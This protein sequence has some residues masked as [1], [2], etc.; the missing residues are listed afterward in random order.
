MRVRESAGSSLSPPPAIP[1]AATREDVIS[2]E[3]RA[4]EQKKKMA[5]RNLVKGTKPKER[6][7]VVHRVHGIA[8]AVSVRSTS[9]PLPLLC[10]PSHFRRYTESSTP[11][12]S[13]Q[14]ELYAWSEALCKH[15]ERKAKQSHTELTTAPSP[16]S[17]RSCAVSCRLL[18]ILFASLRYRLSPSY[19]CLAHD[20]LSTCREKGTHR[21]THT[22]HACLGVSSYANSLP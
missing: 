8:S 1:H 3:K 7:Y 9:S 20:W 18:V 17:P 11:F 10:P 14:G 2:G 5:E 6:I 15:A 12:A 13:V 21:C 16:S 22:H 4:E 19:S